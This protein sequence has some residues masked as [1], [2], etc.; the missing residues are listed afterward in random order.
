MHLLGGN[1]T[2]SLETYLQSLNIL[3]SSGYNDEAI[4]VALVLSAIG[5]VHLK[6]GCFVEATVTL[7]QCMKIFDSNGKIVFFDRLLDKYIV[8]NKRFFYNV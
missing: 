4:E 1:L 2:A 6:K 3:R 5:Q 7:Q 8:A